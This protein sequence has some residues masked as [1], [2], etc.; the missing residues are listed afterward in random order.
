M[1][2]VSIDRHVCFYLSGHVASEV[3]AAQ[4]LALG[5]EVQDDGRCE[6]VL[7]GAATLCDFEDVN[8]VPGA[9]SSSLIGRFLEQDDA[10]K[11][12]V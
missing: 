3:E 1:G 8:A 12:I 10:C 6:L 5:A 9:Q 2:L 11:T 4:S 7:C